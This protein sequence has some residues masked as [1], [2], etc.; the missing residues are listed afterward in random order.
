MPGARH[1]L[2]R[3][4]PLSLYVHIPWCVRKCPYCDF[5]SH[6]VRGELP[7]QPYVGALVRDLEQAL[8]SVWGRRVYSIFIGGGTPSLFSAHAID[9]LLS[10]FRA[11][12]PLAPDCEITL[13]ANPG[14]FEAE[15][16]RDYRALGLSRLS[17]GVQSF[18]SKHLQALGRIHDDTEARR[19]IGI[20]LEQ[21]DNVNLDL[22]Y[23]LPGQTLAEAEADARAALSFGT[24][25]LSFYHLTIEPNTLFHR[26]P[27]RVPDDDA[28]AAMQDLV[29]E[30]LAAEGYAH[31]ETSAYAKPGRECRHNLNYWRFGDYLGIGAGAHSKLSF[32]DRIVRQMRY[33]QPKAYLEQ[34]AQGTP[35]QEENEV[36]QH[37]IVFEFMMNALRLTEGFPVALFT[38]R[39]GLPVTAAAS[40]LDEAESRGLIR[41]DHERIRP[42]ELG[43]RFLNDLLQ[44]FLTGE[45][46]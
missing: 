20:A 36:P 21:F 25:H 44:I 33:K 22:M 1:R 4:P 28:A 29:E 34:V 45:G 16:F 31:Y 17:I 12:L 10:A 40:A 2:E 24:P 14:T 37:D 35:V 30:Q 38:E 9:E 27:P 3:L 43:R 42:T 8:P 32:P 41:R 5:N 15:K 39:T 7:E 23:A 6:E 19:A 46:R 11:R 26:N 18:N 13:E